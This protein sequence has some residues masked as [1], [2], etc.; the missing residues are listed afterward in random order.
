M[1][2]ALIKI[3]FHDVIYVAEGADLTAQHEAEI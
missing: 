3:G 2:A 1:K